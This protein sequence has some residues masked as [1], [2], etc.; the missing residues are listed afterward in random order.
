MSIPNLYVGGT[1]YRNADIIKMMTILGDRL[2]EMRVEKGLSQG[3]VASYANVSQSTL[4]DL[5][6]GEIAPKTIDAVVSLA[7]YFDVSTDY[8]LGL[9]EDRR[10]HQG[11]PLPTY[12]S[13]IVDIALVMSDERRLE[14]LGHAQVIL[15]AQQRAENAAQL[16]RMLDQV[17]AIGGDEA[18]SAL[19]DILEMADTDEAAAYAMLDRFIANQGSGRRRRPNGAQKGSDQAKPASLA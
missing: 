16:S 12:T 3:Q 10:Q 2:K 17:Q 5:E 13:E 7:A 1:D 6:R 4:S 15:D 9:T 19:L 18:M 11:A 8:L 14:L